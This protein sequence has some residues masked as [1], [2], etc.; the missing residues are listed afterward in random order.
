[1]IVSWTRFSSF[2]LSQLGASV[3]EKARV[4]TEPRRLEVSWSHIVLRKA[5]GH[6]AQAISAPDHPVMPPETLAPCAAGGSTFRVAGI[7]GSPD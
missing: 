2:F 1:M 5:Q 4:N 6:F 7:H 3:Q